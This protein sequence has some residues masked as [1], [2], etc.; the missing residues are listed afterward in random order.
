[1]QMCLHTFFELKGDI[2]EWYYQ[3]IQQVQLSY[4]EDP[5]YCF[6]RDCT[7]FNFPLTV[8]NTYTPALNAFGLS[9]TGPLTGVRWY[10]LMAWISILQ[11][12]NDDEQFFYVPAGHLFFVVVGVFENSLFSFFHQALFILFS[13]VEFFLHQGLAI[14]AFSDI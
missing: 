13:I 14:R 1:M 11:M 10:L 5:P 12:I 8:R 7:S 2:Q 4:L 9:D 6:Y 3:V